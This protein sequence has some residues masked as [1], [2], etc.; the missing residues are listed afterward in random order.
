MVPVI[1][2][3]ASSTRRNVIVVFSGTL[4][5]TRVSVWD[6]APCCSWGAVSGINCWRGI[7]VC[8]VVLFI[9][10]ASLGRVIFVLAFLLRAHFA[11]FCVTIYLA[12]G[13]PA[14]VHPVLVMVPGAVLA[15]VVVPSR[16][17]LAVFVFLAVPA[18]KKK[19][20]IGFVR[21]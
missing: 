3:I 7:L 5:T 9:A 21:G 10:H 4:V 15:F 19:M 18:D 6:P 1:I 20:F 8:R 17:P 14:T 11:C 12:D 13:C 16:V 2:I